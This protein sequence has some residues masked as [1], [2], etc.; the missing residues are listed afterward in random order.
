[1]VCVPPDLPAFFFFL[2]FFHYWYFCLLFQEFDLNFQ[3]PNKRNQIKSPHSNDETIRDN[4]SQSEPIRKKEGISFPQMSPG[5]RAA[6]V[7]IWCHIYIWWH[8]RHKLA[9]TSLCS[10]LKPAGFWAEIWRIFILS[11][12]RIFF[13]FLTKVCVK[14]TPPPSLVTGLIFVQTLMINWTFCCCF[15]KLAPAGW[16]RLL[17]PQLPSCVFT[18]KEETSQRVIQGCISGEIPQGDP[19]KT[20]AEA[21]S[22]PQFWA[23]Y[24]RRCHLVRNQWIHIL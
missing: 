9:G 1:M 4:Q 3:A 21:S 23:F 11:I 6:T 18:G 2:L 7:M 13:F 10:R 17:Q 14:L 12:K 16:E 5:W 22:W 19:M 20:R 15:G 8:L 24:H